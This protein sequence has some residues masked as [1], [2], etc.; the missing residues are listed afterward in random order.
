MNMY[1]K[2]DLIC[3]RNGEYITE[4]LLNEN[5]Y[6]HQHYGT[7]FVSVY[8]ENV[9]TIINFQITP[10]INKFFINLFA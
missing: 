4:I 3:Q 9:L 2:L 6:F 10:I 7:C 5:I 8:N 1:K